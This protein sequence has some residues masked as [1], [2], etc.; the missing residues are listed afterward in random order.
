MNNRAPYDHKRL[1]PVEKAVERTFEPQNCIRCKHGM[2]KKQAGN[3]LCAAGVELIHMAKVLR[4]VAG[5]E[6]FVPV[7]EKK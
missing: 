4:G 3:Q 7:Q 2:S 1:T 6:C 5:C